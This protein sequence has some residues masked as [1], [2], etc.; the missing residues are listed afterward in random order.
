MKTI[1]ITTTSTKHPQNMIEIFSH[2]SLRRIL[3]DFSAL[4]CQEI[5]FETLTKYSNSY[6][7]RYLTFGVGFMNEY[8]YKLRF[9]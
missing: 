9:Y 3:L 7:G 8:F 2:V 5:C 1:S 4:S 6:V